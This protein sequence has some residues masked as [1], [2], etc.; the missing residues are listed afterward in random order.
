MEEK[1][2]KLA[3]IDVDTTEVTATGAKFNTAA[4]FGLFHLFSYI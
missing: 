1:L 3:Q 2:V 4:D